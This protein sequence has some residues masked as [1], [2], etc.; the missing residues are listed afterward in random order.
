[1]NGV[2]I[3]YITEILL[4]VIAGVAFVFFMIRHFQ[5]GR[6]FERCFEHKYA[7][8]AERRRKYYFWFKLSLFPML[9]SSFWYGDLED[10]ELLSLRSKTICSF[11]FALL[12][13]L[14]RSILAVVLSWISA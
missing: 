8:I 6:K 9:S 11:I 5:F 12:V 10:E 4:S 2:L 1:M 7:E 13:L 3:I 14:L